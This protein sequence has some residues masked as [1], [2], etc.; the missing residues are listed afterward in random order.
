MATTY[1][2]AGFGQ[3]D[4]VTSTVNLKAKLVLVTVLWLSSLSSLQSGIVVIV[5]GLQTRPIIA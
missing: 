1:E 5:I 3:L 4:V 2:T